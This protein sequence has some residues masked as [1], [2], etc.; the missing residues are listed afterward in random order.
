VPTQ[1]AG[2]VRFDAVSGGSAITCGLSSGVAYCWGRVGGRAYS[3]PSLPDINVPVVIAGTPTLGAITVGEE[4]ACALT[5]GGEA[6]CW[7]INRTGQL[8]SGNALSSGTP[9][10]VLG[11][12]Q[13]T[14]MSAGSAHNCAIT[15]AGA[16][17]CWGSDERGQLGDVATSSCS[18][19]DPG[20]KCSSV[21][22][23]VA[24][25]LQLTGIAAGG[26]HTCAL[27]SDGAAWCWGANDQGQL[28]I[29]STG[30]DQETPEAVTGGH[31]FE[32]IAAGGGFTC[33]IVT[34]GQAYCW[35]ANESF[36]L[37]TGNTTSQSSPVP[38]NTTQ[39]FA[40]L[41]AG[42]LQTCAVT[43]DGVGWCWGG[44]VLFELGSGRP[45]FPD[46]LLRLP[47]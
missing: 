36:Q 1:V 16:G 24:G 6:W 18:L 20:A 43:S 46:T 4:Y 44:N 13:F 39:R 9:A 31:H 17:W 29:G 42:L 34:G 11:S 21:P 38:V 25:A 22:V 23:L 7:G 19:V 32:A 28:G 37:G 12:H 8:G 47:G 41:E 35:G 10:A 27:A 26:R 45:K 33:G 2:T 5:V 14:R 30:G 15:A 40:S 3:D